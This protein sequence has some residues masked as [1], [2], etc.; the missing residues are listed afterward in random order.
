MIMSNYITDDVL[1]EI[2]L[3]CIKEWRQA[4]H[5]SIIVII[6][7]DFPYVEAEARSSISCTAFK[8]RFNVEK[9]KNFRI[10]SFEIRDNRGEELNNRHYT[11]SVINA[12]CQFF[13]KVGRLLV[14]WIGFPLVDWTKGKVSINSLGYTEVELKFAVKVKSREGKIRFLIL[15]SLRLKTC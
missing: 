11:K 9:K 2:T 3:L 4:R 6:A 13:R 10:S 8:Y 1:V 7:H 12:S 5:L 15:K 14:Q